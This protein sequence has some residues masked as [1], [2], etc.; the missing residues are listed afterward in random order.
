MVMELPSH[1]HCV[2]NIR[3]HLILVTACRRPVI[4]ATLR[5]DL[6]RR[7]RRVCAQAEVA[8]LEF[9]GE[10][11]HV[12]LLLEMHPNIQPSKLVNSIKTVSSRMMRRDHWKEVRKM[13]WGARCWSRSYCFISVGDGATTEII[14][15]YIQGQ[16][17]PA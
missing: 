5:V 13:R 7:I 15:R 4:T 11:D 6:E 3:A 1:P 8:V 17:R 12:H 2:F 16:D 10:A 14:K 9:S